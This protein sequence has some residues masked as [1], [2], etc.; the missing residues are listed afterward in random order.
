M[1]RQNRIAASSG[2]PPICSHLDCHV[3]GVA[4]QPLGLDKAARRAPEPVSTGSR[5]ISAILGAVAGI[6]EHLPPL[7]RGED[8]TTRPGRTDVER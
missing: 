2:D 6:V 3:R 7:K 8:P 4:T 1:S 5:A